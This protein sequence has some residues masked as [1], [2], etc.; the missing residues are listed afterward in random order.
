MLGLANGKIFE[1]RTLMKKCVNGY[2]TMSTIKTSTPVDF[3]CPCFLCQQQ[4]VKK[5]GEGERRRVKREKE[6][7]QRRVKKEHGCQ[8][9]VV[10]SIDLTVE[11]EPQ[12]QQHLREVQEQLQH[13]QQQQI[14]TQQQQQGH[15]LEMQ[16]MQEHYLQQLQQQIAQLQLQQQPQQLQQQQQSLQL[17]EQLAGINLDEPMESAP[18]K[19]EEEE[20]R[21]SAS[22]NNDPIINLRGLEELPFF[23]GYSRLRNRYCLR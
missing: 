7:E 19:D 1:I 14:Q 8:N 16:Q 4:A 12:Q 9:H 6:G 11:D 18:V 23:L 21:F 2:Q 17:Q 20:D 10:A 3:Y 22:C 13:Q 15:Q 5:E